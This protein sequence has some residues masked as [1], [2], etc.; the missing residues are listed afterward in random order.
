MEESRDKQLD[1]APSI[2]TRVVVG[3]NAEVANDTHQFV[4][5]DIG[6][7]LASFSGGGEQLSTNGHEA[8]KEVGM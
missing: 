6:A 4:S 3:T 7:D 1:H 2:V 5:I 8:V